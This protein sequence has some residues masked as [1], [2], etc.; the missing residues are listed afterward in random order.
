[1]FSEYL[2]TAYLLIILVAVSMNRF[3]VFWRLSWNSVS[4][5]TYNAPKYVRHSIKTIKEGTEGVV[6]ELVVYGNYSSDQTVDL[7]KKC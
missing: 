5:L 2:A 7:L 3:V 4:L 6:Y 1:M